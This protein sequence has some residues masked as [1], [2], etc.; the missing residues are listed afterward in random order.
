M[1]LPELELVLT[2]LE[3]TMRADL[4]ENAEE[5]ARATGTRPEHVDL[6][7]VWLSL[8]AELLL[9]TENPTVPVLDGYALLGMVAVRLAGCG[10]YP[11]PS[12][13]LK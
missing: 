3:R 11:S 2:E 1:N 10:C 12:S 7:D 8:H 4:I 13:A 9:E 5:T 6:V